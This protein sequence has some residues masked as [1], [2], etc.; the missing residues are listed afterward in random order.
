MVDVPI[1]S[2]GMLTVT[3]RVTGYRWWN[4][5]MWMMLRCFMLARFVAPKNVNVEIEH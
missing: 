5:R 3:V 4:V 2:V 1:D